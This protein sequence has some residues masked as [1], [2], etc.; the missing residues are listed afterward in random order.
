MG[1]IIPAILPSS[2][3]D[4]DE[5]LSRLQGKEVTRV[6]IDVVDGRFASPATWPYAEG[7]EQFAQMIANG[8]T[9]PYL[10]ELKYEI[11]LM[12]QDPD[13][14][15]GMWVAAGASKITLHAESTNY[16]AHVMA[17]L[18]K[19]YGHDKD[20]AP[21]LIS[22]GLAVNVFTDIALLDPYM[23]QVEYVQ[24]MGIASIGKQGEP[25]DTRVLD[26]I[27]MFKK[28][29]PNVKVQVDGGVSLMTAPDLLD[30]GVHELVVGSA[31]WR[32]SNL[33]VELRKFA[34]IA[35]EHGIYE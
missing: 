24:F 6:Q 31:L 26:K 4:L 12:V 3:A 11:D 5:K 33:E 7:S 16:L 9:L 22:F 28:R 14:V 19:E 27:R 32:A 8:E 34:R 15:L 25:F 1:I 17:G 30:A 23:D 18:R 20:F 2:R 35:E 13:Q 21:D 10:G 29:N